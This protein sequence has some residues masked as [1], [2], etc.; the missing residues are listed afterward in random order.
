MKRLL[1][2]FMTLLAADAYC[3]EISFGELR[4]LA[5]SGKSLT[6][7]ESLELSGVVISIPKH[8]NL[9]DGVQVNFRSNSSTQNNRT[10]YMQS[11]DGKH[12]VKLVFQHFDPEGAKATR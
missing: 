6:V 1:F 3:R 12:G 2:I 10:A 4:T 9:A 7:E 5:A 8:E 11:P